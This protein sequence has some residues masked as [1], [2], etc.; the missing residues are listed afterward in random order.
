MYKFENL[1]INKSGRPTKRTKELLKSI[2]EYIEKGNTENNAAYLAG[3]SKATYYEWKSRFPEFAD[4]VKKAVSVRENLWL[5]GIRAAAY[6]ADK[7]LVK[8]WHAYAWLLERTN[9]KEYAL[10]I[11]MEEE[12]RVKHEHTINAPAELVKSF[13]KNL[14][15]L[16]SLPNDS[17]TQANI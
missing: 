15:K 16:S 6:D 14:A 5:A 4:Q 9:R 13:A 11:R 7:Q 3:I 10:G 1:K 8:D 12:G 17:D 2:C